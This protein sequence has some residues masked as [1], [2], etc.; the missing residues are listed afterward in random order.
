MRKRGKTKELSMHYIREIYRLFFHCQQSKRKIARSCGISRGSVV[1]YI[2][3]FQKSCLNYEQIQNMDDASLKE[4][5]KRPHRE[6]KR[7]GRPIPEWP[8]IHQE[9][10][11]KSVTLRL[12]WEEYLE[13]HPDGYQLTQ[14][15]HRYRQWQKVQ[16][17]S[18]RQIHK[19]GEKL[20]VDYAGQT[21][22]ILDKRTGKIDFEAQIFIATLGASNYTYAEATRSQQLE[23]WLTSH[24]RAFEFFGGTTEI[25]VP[26]NLKSGVTKACFYDPEINRSYLDLAEH[27]G[28]VII[29]ARSRKP[30]DKAKVENAV[31]VA[32]RWILASLRNRSFFSLQELNQAIEELL[33]KLNNRGFQKIP[34]S[35]RSQFETL[36]KAELKPLPSER[37]VFAEWKKARVNIDYH[38]ELNH[39]YYSV[40]YQLVQQVVYVKS[41]Q[42]IVEIFHNHKRIASH[43][44]SD[45]SSQHTTITE[46]MPKSHQNVLWSPQKILDW[47][48]KIGPA[49]EGLCDLIFSHLKHPQQGYRSCLGILRLSKNYGAERLNAA[50]HRAIAIGGYSYKSVH[51]ILKNGLDRERLT[52]KS[53][54]VSTHHQNVRGKEYFQEAN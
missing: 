23:D 14:F 50:C 11:K 9:L 54:T 49:T 20:F 37:Y 41:T 53:K 40:P 7:S 27:Y 38:I 4:S 33:E 35:R 46:H 6:D 47:A 30:K 45:R 10:K 36:E 31:L 19:F 26:D 18:M 22:P 16:K 12:L 25:V 2:R 52:A 28:I 21:I 34:G 15:Y 44:R 13:E 43:V 1:N 8:L 39:H 5:L 48:H 32:E 17:L 3:Q 29:P 24:V 42:M 51:S